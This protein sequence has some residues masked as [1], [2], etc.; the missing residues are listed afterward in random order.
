MSCPRHGSDFIVERHDWFF[1]QPMYLCTK[2]A[3]EL[4]GQRCVVHLH[5]FDVVKNMISLIECTVTGRS[6][7]AQAIAA[8]IKEM[9]RCLR[10]QGGR[11]LSS[12]CSQCAF[13]EACNVIREIGEEY[14]SDGYRDGKRLA[15][16]RSAQP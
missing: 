13:S 5:A 9:Y 15:E 14:Y 10:Y 4:G 2:C 11:R 16:E 6:A 8:K 12:D 3:S 7:E 1:R